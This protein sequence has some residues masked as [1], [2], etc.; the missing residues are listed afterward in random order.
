M[1]FIQPIYELEGEIKTHFT[2]CH[3]GARKDV[4][5][6]WRPTSQVGDREESDTAMGSRH[7]TKHHD[8][9]HNHAQH[10]Y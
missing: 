6:I 5:C 4:E 8:C 7:H 3:K 10:D 1:C 2:K 9:M